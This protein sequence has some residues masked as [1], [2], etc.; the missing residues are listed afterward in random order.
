M[1]ENITPEERERRERILK[2]G[3]RMTMIE[4]LPSLT[5]KKISIRL[6]NRD[7]R[8]LFENGIVIRNTDELIGNWNVFMLTGILPSF[9]RWKHHKVFYK[10][11]PQKQVH[12][13][14]VFILPIIRKEIVWG[15]YRLSHPEFHILINYDVEE[16]GL[17]LRGVRDRIVFIPELGIFLGRFHYK[18]KDDNGETL[19]FV[20]Y[21]TLVPTFAFEEDSE[22][23][24][25]KAEFSGGL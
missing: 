13:H 17:I 3:T 18:L 16:N 10:R 6:N 19:G 2:H 1:R 22:L 7:L 25:L 5:G 4:R 21:F 9:R 12:G 15:R 8:R 24:R 23:G 20:G 11:Y 14:N